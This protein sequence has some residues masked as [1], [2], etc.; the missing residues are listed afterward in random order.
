MGDADSDGVKELLV[1][2]GHPWSVS[3]CYEL[4]E[5]GLDIWYKLCPELVPVSEGGTGVGTSSLYSINV[6]DLL[7]P[8][9]SLH[10][11]K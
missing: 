8:C 1:G 11:A 10:S 2:F 9:R 6:V 4:E 3:R 7:Q 5:N